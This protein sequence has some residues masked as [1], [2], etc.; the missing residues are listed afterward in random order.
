MQ[1]RPEFEDKGPLRL[2]HLDRRLR[3]RITSLANLGDDLL[4]Q[5]LPLH[6]EG[7][8]L[9]ADGPYDTVHVPSPSRWSSAGV[10][11]PQ[12]AAR[13]LLARRY[14]EGSRSLDTPSD[15][16]IYLAG[17]EGLEPP[18]TGFGDRFRQFS[19]LGVCPKVASDLG[20]YPPMLAMLSHRLL[21]SCGLNATWGGFS[22][23]ETHPPRLEIRSSVEALFRTTGRY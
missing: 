6:L 18:T 2:Q 7:F 13:F 8:L 1:R 10:A 4:R 20:I 12:T 16:G 9:H 5:D 11:L 17:R 21:T 15:L 14:E 23:S 3:S 22:P 19:D